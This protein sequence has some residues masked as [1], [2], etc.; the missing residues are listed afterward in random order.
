MD[1]VEFPIVSLR[2]RLEIIAIFANNIS[3]GVVFPPSSL[4]PLQ[5]DFRGGVEAVVPPSKV[6]PG[7]ANSNR[8][9]GK[10]PDTN[11]RIAPTISISPPTTAH[12]SRQ[13]GLSRG[14]DPPRTPIQSPP[15]ALAPFPTCTNL[16]P[17][18][19]ARQT[20]E[21][22][23]NPLRNGFGKFPTVSLKIDAK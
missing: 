7:G 21:D 19:I 9:P 13:V 23:P 22:L 14:V 8:I 6:P 2:I 17:V 3:A 20:M 16:H 1:S 5:G 11:K 18:L 4:F 15:V 10:S 12:G